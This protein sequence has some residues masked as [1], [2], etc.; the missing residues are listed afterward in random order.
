MVNWHKL[1][2]NQSIK[3]LDSR[4]QGLTD[5]EASD[6]LKRWGANQLQSHKPISPYRLL[7]KQF[8]NYFI[9]VLLFAAG[10]AYGVSFMPGQSERR[11]TAFFIL[12]II[13]LSVLLSFFEEYR[14]QKELEALSR[15]LMFNT[16]VL[17]NGTK[18]GIDASQVV[19]GDVLVLSQG[20]KVP[21]DARLFETHSLRADESTLTGESIG[22]DKTA[23]YVPADT[24]LAERSS[25]VYG[26]TFITH[27][28]GLALVVSTGS[29]SEVGQ[30]AATLESMSER[31]TP[32]QTEVKKMARQ[33]TWI[34][35][36]LA[37]VVAFIL[38]FVLHETLVDVALNTLS[39]TVATIPESLPIVLTFALALGAR[40][41]ARE[42][43]VVR[44]LSVVESL[45]SVDT[46][47]TDKTGTLTQT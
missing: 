34:I 30:I 17:R 13:I 44:N 27:G 16:T 46:I 8:T 26:S 31:P 2:I 29:A 36:I 10:L 15:L 35:S 21:A 37:A 41:M 25:M 32:F 20:K 1:S 47:C 42:G 39:L 4:P 7:L 19:P 38:Y 23:E 43:A 18:R 5:A 22:V 45:G 24:P 12:G 33:M 40:Q 11:L 6:R 9:L 3:Q 28:T 14:S